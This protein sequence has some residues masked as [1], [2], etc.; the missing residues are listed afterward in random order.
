[1]KKNSK[2]SKSKEN[3][4]N[5]AARVIQRAIRRYLPKKYVTNENGSLTRNLITARPIPKSLAVQ[6]ATPSG[7]LRWWD[8]TGLYDWFIKLKKTELRG[9]IAGLPKDKRD[10]IELKQALYETLLH[11]KITLQR[12]KLVNQRRNIRRVTAN[13][14]MDSINYVLYVLQMILSIVVI[15]NVTFAMFAIQEA[16]MVSDGFNTLH[17]CSMD[18]YTINKLERI[19]KRLNQIA[20]GILMWNSNIAY[21]EILLKREE[22]LGLD[23]FQNTT[24]KLQKVANKM[25]SLGVIR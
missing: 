11:Q 8:A 7:L 10:E 23:F 18:R 17:K 3:Q 5:H 25:R 13:A 20:D 19:E 21:I 16:P 1:M 12:K 6:I 15:I 14:A 22:R 9:L 24:N 4:E 2:N